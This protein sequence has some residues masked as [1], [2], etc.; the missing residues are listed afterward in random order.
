MHT[1]A[2]SVHYRPSVLPGAVRTLYFRNGQ[3][4]HRGT[5]LDITLAGPR[6]GAVF[7]KCTAPLRCLRRG[8][9]VIPGVN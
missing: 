5:D 3:A 9:T 2:G 8:Y 7:G 1:G 6:R 4:Y